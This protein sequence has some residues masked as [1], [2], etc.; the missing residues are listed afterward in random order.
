[1]NNTIISN[2]Y[3]CYTSEHPDVHYNN[4]E[5]NEYAVYVGFWQSPLINATDNWWGASDGPSGN[6]TGSGDP[7]SNYIHYIPWFTEPN[8]YAGPR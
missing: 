3:G 2:G 7:I 1:M 5:N 4:F 6:G 8:P